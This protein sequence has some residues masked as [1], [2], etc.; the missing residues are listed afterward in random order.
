MDDNAEYDPADGSIEDARRSSCYIVEEKYSF[1]MTP[2]A[3]AEENSVARQL[4]TVDSA[5][6]AGQPDASNFITSEDPIAGFVT[7]PT[8]NPLHVSL[9]M[10][11]EKQHRAERSSS[12]ASFSC[13]S[14]DSHQSFSRLSNNN[15]FSPREQTSAYRDTAC[16]TFSFSSDSGLY[17]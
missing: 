4:W 17:L 15:S 14:L 16:Q 11:P 12:T 8:A 13:I 3:A 9:I 10:T 7:P 6:Q 1:S 2:T 5:P